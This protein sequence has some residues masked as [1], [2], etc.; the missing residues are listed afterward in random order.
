MPPGYWDDR[1]N[2]DHYMHWLGQR[3]GF[4][5]MED[6]YRLTTKD[7]SRNRGGGLL[8]RHWNFSVTTAVKDTFRDY[9]WKEWLFQQAPRGF[10]QDPRNHH[11]YMAWLASQLGVRRREQ[12][13]RVTHGDFIEHQGESFLVRYCTTVSAAVKAHLPEYPW[14]EWLFSSTPKHFWRERRNRRRYM[15][16]LGEQ[17]GFRR[18]EDWY[19]VTID[20]FRK[21][22]G[23]QLL[24][25]Y[26]TSPIAAVKE[27]FPRRRWNEWMFSRVPVDFWRHSINRRRYL[28][29]LGK[30]LGYRRPADWSRLRDRDVTTNYGGGLLAAYGSTAELLRRSL[31][32]VVRPAGLLGRRSPRG[33][34]ARP[35]RRS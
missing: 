6:W 2:R 3:L 35:K 4:R 17:L 26:K 11:R 13:Y 12:W 30:Q 20:D 31:L 23:L 24:R 10:W 33:R 5:K 7:F 14:K 1:A 22:A 18:P 15:A 21:H 27:Y 25:R 32:D 29:W 9:D 8:A 19:A 16:W 34:R 28:Q